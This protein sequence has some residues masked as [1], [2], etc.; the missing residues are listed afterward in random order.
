LDRSFTLDFDD[1]VDDFVDGPDEVE[2]R[3][4]VDFFCPVDDGPGDAERLFSS[5]SFGV[6]DDPEKIASCVDSDSFLSAD[7]PD[8]LDRC[9]LFA[10]CFGEEPG[11]ALA[12]DSFFDD[13]EKID[14]CVDLDC[15]LSADDPD[16]LD[17]CFLFTW[18][19]G[20]EPAAALANVSVEPLRRYPSLGDCFPAAR[21]FFF[22]SISA[23][24]SVDTL[25]RCSSLPSFCFRF[26]IISF[27]SAVFIE[28]LSSLT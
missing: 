26:R 18:G 14:S 19:F 10:C 6:F 13:P 5:L 23:M 2:R 22:F 21:F 28:L 20:E 16:D 11:A 17:R 9:F 12:F 15:F 27:P 7:D 24:E 25:R 3:R 8:E 4:T 1:F